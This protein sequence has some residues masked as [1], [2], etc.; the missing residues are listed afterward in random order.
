MLCAHVQHLGRGP[1]RVPMCGVFHELAVYDF[2]AHTK[3]RQF[4]RGVNVT[5]STRVRTRAIF[6]VGDGGHIRVHEI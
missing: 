2:G 6:T 5:S 4:G 3:M 1:T